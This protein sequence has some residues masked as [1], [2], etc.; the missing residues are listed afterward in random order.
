[1][2]INLE[3]PL[4]LLVSFESN[5]GHGGFA[6]AKSSSSVGCRVFTRVRLVME[7]YR[8]NEFYKSVP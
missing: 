3:M 6:V 7:W 2:G 5:G 4:F 1:M 8:C